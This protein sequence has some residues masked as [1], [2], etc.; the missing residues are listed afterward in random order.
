MNNKFDELAKNMAQSV[1]RRGALKKFGVGLAGIALASLFALPAH[2]TD[3]KR[4]PLVQLSSTSPWPGC[5]P[6][7]FG[8]G[9]LAD[10]AETEPHFSVNPVNPKNLV[11]VWTA[12]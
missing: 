11:A 6:G 10:N 3:F 4:G 9:P 2:A 7:G 1:T 12:G 8:P 5:D